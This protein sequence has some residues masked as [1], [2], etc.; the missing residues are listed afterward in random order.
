MVT[1]LDIC[2]N[3]KLFSRGEKI[4]S[5]IYSMDTQKLFETKQDF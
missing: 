5:L 3:L 2:V 4:V 1:E